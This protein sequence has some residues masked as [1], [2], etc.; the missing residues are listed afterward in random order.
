M[1]NA[2][3]PE[4][5]DDPEVM[6]ESA[7]LPVRELLANKRVFLGRLMGFSLVAF[8]LLTA[9]FFSPWLEDW[10]GLRILVGISALGNLGALVVAAQGRRSLGRLEK[11]L[12][13]LAEKEN[14]Q[15]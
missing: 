4:D 10:M 12:N 13:R 9:F 5:F 2:E 11:V 3:P 14:G 15:P 7:E 6:V 8:G 1:S